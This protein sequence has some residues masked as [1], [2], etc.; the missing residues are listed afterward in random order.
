MSSD[1]SEELIPVSYFARLRVLKE[2]EGW[3]VRDFSGDQTELTLY[4]KLPDDLERKVS[5]LMVLD[6]DE[7]LEGVGFRYN[8][9][10]FYVDR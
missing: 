1:I 10:T 6:N 8:D 9:K 4:E 2:G 5:M 3:S 7:E